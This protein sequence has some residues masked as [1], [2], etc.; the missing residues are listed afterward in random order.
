MFKKR[1]KTI[2]AGSKLINRYVH[3]TYRYLNNINEFKKAKAALRKFIELKGDMLLISDNVSLSYELT[4]K[5]NLKCKMCYGLRFRED[6]FSRDR[7]TYS[8]LGYD[9]V[10]KVLKNSNISNVSFVG[11]EVLLRNDLFLI[12]DYLKNKNVRFSILTNGILINNDTV[13][14]LINFGALLTSIVIS[15]D[16]TKAIHDRIRNSNNA[17]EQ[18]CRGIKLATPHFNVILNTTIMQENLH[19]LKGVVDIAHLLGVKNIDFSLEYWCSDEE[20]V[21][22]KKILNREFNWQDPIISVYNKQ[23][24]EYSFQELRLR[25]NELRNYSYNKG[26]FITISPAQEYLKKYFSR[27]IKPVEGII[28]KKLLF[29]N[30]RVDYKG[31]F[32]FC[33]ALRKSWGNLTE[34][35]AKEVWESK[36]FLDF[37]WKLYKIGMLPI[38]KRCC[39]LCTIF[40]K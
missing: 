10:I 21:E 27:E 24:T 14:K 1:L 19:D 2:I 3:F 32:I 23:G 34:K 22:S 35:T 13:S 18:A 6:V 9:R 20:I 36:E 25:L 8:E 29:P 12:L 30:P 33:Q 28:C 11:N 26:I 39:K 15:L 31:D 17:F 37:R 16:G 40:C 7:A 38:C 4:L 5:C